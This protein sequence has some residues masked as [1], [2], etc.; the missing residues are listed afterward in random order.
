MLLKKSAENISPSPSLKKKNQTVSLIGFRFERQHDKINKMASV[1]S[2][3]S[4]QPVLTCS[5]IRVFAVHL[6]SLISVF[7]VHSMGS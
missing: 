3:D 5:Q 2:E 4:D 6:R 7:A 1:Q